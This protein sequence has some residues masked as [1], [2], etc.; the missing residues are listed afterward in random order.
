MSGVARTKSAGVIVTHDIRETVIVRPPSPNPDITKRVDRMLVGPDTWEQLTDMNVARAGF[1][2]FEY[3]DDIIAIGGTDGSAIHKTA[4]RYDFAA[5]EW[6]LIASMT[7]P[8]AYY[9]SIFTGG[10]IYVIGGVTTD[11]TGNLIIS[12]AIERYDPANNTWTT[13][14]A[15]PTDYNVAFGIAAVNG[16][17]I[18]VLS[19]YRQSLGIL[20]ASILRYTIGSDTWTVIA[21]LIDEDAQL[22]QRILPFFFVNS[23]DVYV[24]DG[25][26]YQFDA[27][28]EGKGGCNTI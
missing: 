11:G 23:T 20:N 16:G 1:S 22:Y 26:R 21:E 15:M 18:F 27:T 25:L 24:L 8:R 13:L 12:S 2:M 4:E 10:Y 3:G 19:G 9:Q 17:N 5:D 7:I 28:D 14:T 6:N